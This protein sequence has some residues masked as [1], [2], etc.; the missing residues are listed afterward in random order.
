M[1]LPN[2]TVAHCDPD[3]CIDTAY[4]APLTLSLALELAAVDRRVPTQTQA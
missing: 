3:E 4:G 2:N 1:P